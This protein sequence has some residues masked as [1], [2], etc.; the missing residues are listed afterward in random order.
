M[1]FDARYHEQEREL[2][3][4]QREILERGEALRAEISNQVDLTNEE[5]ADTYMAGHAE[6]TREL[7]DAAD[8]LIGNVESEREELERKVHEG[9]GERFAQYLIELADKSE[10]EL[11]PLMQTAL[12]TG[13]GDL[14]RAIAQTAYEKNLSSITGGMFAQWAQS[15]PEAAQAL[16]RL[17]SLP[18]SDRLEDRAK[19]RAWVPKADLRSLMPTPEALERA[20]RVAAAEQERNR[21]AQTRKDMER[22]Q[23]FG[24]PVQRVGRRRA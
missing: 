20:R 16:E 6:L 4:K 15:N 22:V 2:E 11:R 19:G 24:R 17:H 12:R 8:A 10:E 14:A 7:Q 23:V 5:R 13:Q 3:D 1:E 9:A 18:P 21:I